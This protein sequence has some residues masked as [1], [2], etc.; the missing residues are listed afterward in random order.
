MFTTVDVVDSNGDC[1]YFCTV[2]A[3]QLPRSSGLT[4]TKKINDSWTTHQ[5]RT[6]RRGQKA[7]DT[8]NNTANTYKSRSTPKRGRHTRNKAKEECKWRDHDTAA[9]TITSGSANTSTI[10]HYINQRNKTKNIRTK[11][12]NLCNLFRKV[13]QNVPSHPVTTT[14]WRWKRSSLH[15]YNVRERNVLS[16]T[17]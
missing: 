17:L 14:T 7:R 1:G 6:L 9:E 11:L 3:K 12:R 2:G 15:P 4:H 10:L 13:I 5:I 16:S 8:V